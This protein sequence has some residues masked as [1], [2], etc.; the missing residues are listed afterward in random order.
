MMRKLV[1]SAFSTIAVFGLVGF[2]AEEKPEYTTKQVMKEAHKDGLLKKV[3]EG[4]ASDEEKGKLL[5]LYK[6]MLANDPPKGPADG[7]KTK[8]E[9]IVVAT[10]ALIAGEDGAAEKLTAAVNCKACHTPHKP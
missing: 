6:A 2:A 10:E 5:V 8:G 1:F 3:T 9:A 4:K 7:W